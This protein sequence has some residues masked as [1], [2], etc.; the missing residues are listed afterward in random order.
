MS[1]DKIR[2]IL[3]TISWRI[4]GTLDTIF[5]SWLVTGE[6]STGLAIGMIEI[7]TK[8]ILYYAHER[9]WYNWIRL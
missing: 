2:H 5:L 4:I 8:S 1:K 6:F 9:A 7:V 3:K